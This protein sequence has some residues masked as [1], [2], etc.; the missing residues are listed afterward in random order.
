MKNKLLHIKY[1]LRHNEELIL[2]LLSILFFYAIVISSLINDISYFSVL[3][4]ADEAR[5]NLIWKAGLLIISIFTIIS[6]YKRAFLVDASLLA[7]LMLL[8]YYNSFALL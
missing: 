7:H 1:K 2:W 6:R 8:Y 4:E 3:F 5:P